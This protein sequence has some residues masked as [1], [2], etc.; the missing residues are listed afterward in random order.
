MCDDDVTGL[1]DAK[2][3][4]DVGD[5]IDETGQV[6]Y[7]KLLLREG[8][9]LVICAYLFLSSFSNKIKIMVFLI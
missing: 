5:D 9:T 7:L 6:N 3:E 8:K 1:G 2:G 4:K